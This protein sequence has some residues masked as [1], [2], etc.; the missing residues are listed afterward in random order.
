[1]ARLP[2]IHRRQRS[3]R[4]QALDL[5]KGAANTGAKAFVTVKA[6]KVAGRSVAK[7]AAIPAAVAGGV[8]VWRVAHK[9]DGDAAA[10]AS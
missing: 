7:L 6:T 1:M 10:A 5:A 2:F 4:E 3:K 8:V 9:G